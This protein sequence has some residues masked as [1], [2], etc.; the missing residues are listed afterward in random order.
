[1]K[2]KSD[3][4]NIQRAQFASTAMGALIES[5]AQIDD[6]AA[7]AKA[8]VTFANALQTELAANPIPQETDEQ[9]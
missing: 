9:G 6:A 2:T 1:M 8:A 3:F 5:G 4:V 7:V